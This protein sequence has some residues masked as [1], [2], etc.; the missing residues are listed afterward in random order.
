[1]P[2]G[3]F[4]GR[5]AIVTGCG[6]GIGRAISL[7][8]AQNGCKVA[9]ADIMEDNAQKVAEEILAGG[10]EAVAIGVDVSLRDQVQKMALQVATQFGRIDILVNAAG[11]TRD[12]LL[13]KMTEEEWDTVINVNL[14]GT[15]LC[16]Q[17]VTAAMRRNKYGRVI[18]FSSK[19]GAAGNIGQINYCASKAGIIGLTRAVAKEFA[20]YA[21]KEGAD[22]TCNALLPGFID[23]PM[24]EQ[25][26]S[27]IRKA[28]IDEIPLQ[29][30]GKPQEIAK[31]VLFLAAPDAGYLTGTAIG[32][33]GGF[34]MGVTC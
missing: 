34:F 32:V 3:S 10:G 5:T 18:N 17:A 1:M 33:D 8:L 11:V 31:I 6:Q 26:P 14:K 30:S 24:S 12:A 2:G 4:E 22:L 16:T 19:G 15:F 25:I 21:A 7:E 23:T 20:R 29:R 13:E 9:A 28:F 27:G